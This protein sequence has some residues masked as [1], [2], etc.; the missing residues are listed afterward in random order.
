MMKL[1]GNEEYSYEK[2]RENSPLYSNMNEFLNS[3]K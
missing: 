3:V 2:L 1:V